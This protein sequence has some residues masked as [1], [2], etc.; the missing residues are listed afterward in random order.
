MT[1]NKSFENVAKLKDLETMVKIEVAFT[2]KLRA[3]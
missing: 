3:D 2:T 1:E